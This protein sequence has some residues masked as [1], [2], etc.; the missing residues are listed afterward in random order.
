MLAGRATDLECP[1]EWAQDS[2]SFVCNT[3]I[4][5]NPLF[6]ELT[7]I[8]IL[9]PFCPLVFTGYTASDLGGAYYQANA[10][11]VDLQIAKVP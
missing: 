8:P 10:P 1:L 4:Y 6:V 3:G 9:H 7:R 2:N 5:Y 11:I